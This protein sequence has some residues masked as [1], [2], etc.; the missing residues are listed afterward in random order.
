MTPVCDL[1]GDYYSP[2]CNLL[3]APTERGSPGWRQLSKGR[4]VTNVLLT[5]AGNTGGEW[6]KGKGIVTGLLNLG[7]L[8]TYLNGSN[9][10]NNNN[11]NAIR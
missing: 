4:R 5:K 8:I 3:G 7:M 2:V 9:N 10:N 11:N 1:L 6:P